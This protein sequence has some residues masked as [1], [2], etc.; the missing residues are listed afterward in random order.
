MSDVWSQL[1][2]LTRPGRPLGAGS[3][4][5]TRRDPRQFTP[6]Q[7]RALAQRRRLHQALLAEWAD[8]FAAGRTDRQ[9]LVLAGPPGLRDSPWEEAL[10]E[11]T[12]IPTPQWFFVSGDDFEQRLLRNLLAD[13]AYDQLVP[14]EV[15]A[16]ERLV[17]PLDLAPLLREEVTALTDQ[18]VHSSVALGR[19][20]VVDGTL[21][22]PEPADALLTRL[23]EADYT[24]RIVVVDA[25]LEIVETRAHERWRQG[26]EA[27]S[28]E[29][30]G[31]APLAQLGGR[32]LP[33]CGLPDLYALDGAS[34]CLATARDLAERH[35]CVSEFVAYRVYA[36]DGAP[37]PLEHRGR[38]AK[39]GILLEY[40]AYSAVATGL[41]P[42]S[43]EVRHRAAS[44]PA[45]R[46]PRRRPE[47]GVGR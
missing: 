13:E 9:A 1:Q 2:E 4:Y 18:A 7:R 45:R 36:A 33:L 39:G 38:P 17:A 22:R 29:P 8:W 3:P 20:L 14:P 42:M 31:A 27:A 25:E 5:A 35:G 34:I 6:R 19:N 43:R 40:E 44:G 41:P 23:G 12:G 16:L 32:L 21:S 30:A 11:A 46:D 24:V 26:R 15:L 28:E 10:I 47:Q 37:Q